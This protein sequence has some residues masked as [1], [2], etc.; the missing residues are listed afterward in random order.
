MKMNVVEVVVYF[1]ASAEVVEDAEAAPEAEEG[2]NPRPK[3]DC[4]SIL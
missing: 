3:L 2:R 1:Y 4:L